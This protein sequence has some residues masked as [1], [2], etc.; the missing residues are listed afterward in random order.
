M[1]SYNIDFNLTSSNLY[2]FETTPNTSFASMYDP[3][4][5]KVTLLT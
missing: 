1:I 3:T 4:L 2:A 5:G